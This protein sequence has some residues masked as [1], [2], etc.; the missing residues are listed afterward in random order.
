[1]KY[2]LIIICLSPYFLIAQMSKD[3]LGPEERAIMKVIDE[4]TRSYF[5]RDYEAFKNTHVTEDYYRE[6]RYW[7]GW[8]DGVVKSTY[9]WKEKVAQTKTRFNKELPADKW[10]AANYE[11]TKLNIRISKS[12]DMAWVTFYEKAFDPEAKEVHGESYGTRIMEKH[13]GAGKIAYLGYH[14]LP[15]E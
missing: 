3:I 13:K 14:F 10:D 8:K 7:E 11:K 2:L 4:E 9:G 1:M 6:H 12:G 5:A 15:K